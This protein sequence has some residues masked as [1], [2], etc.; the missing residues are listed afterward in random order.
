MNQERFGTETP[1]YHKLHY[2]ARGQL[3]DVRLS[4]VPW[5]TDQ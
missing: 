3:Y 1:V 4:T 2:N 5:A